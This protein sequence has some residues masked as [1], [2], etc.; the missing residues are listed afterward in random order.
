MCE[1]DMP[2]IVG[3]VPIFTFGTLL[4]YWYVGVS[5]NLL[6]LD[7]PKLLPLSAYS[8]FLLPLIS[9]FKFPPKIPS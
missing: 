8:T 9:L 5:W 1:R 2:P 7:L 3:F 4:A 6:F